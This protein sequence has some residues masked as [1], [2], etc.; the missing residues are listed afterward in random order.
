MT[1]FHLDP[2]QFPA[3][4]TRH[5]IVLTVLAVALVVS[6]IMMWK[7]VNAIRESNDIQRELLAS[8][9]AEPAAKTAV[10]ARSDAPAA[11]KA[12]AG[13]RRSASAS[14]GRE[15]NSAGRAVSERTPG[16]QLASTQILLTRQGRQ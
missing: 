7:L 5:Q 8:Q 10:K 2:Q 14:G 13:S 15:R 12:S 1:S 3:A 16:T 9:Q 6:T 11:S 4:H